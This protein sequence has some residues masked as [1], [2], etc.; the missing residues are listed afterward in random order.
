MVGLGRLD[1][2]AKGN[3]RTLQQGKHCLRIQDKEVGKTIRLAE[4]L[5]SF[6]FQKCTNASMSGAPSTSAVIRQRLQEADYQGQR[7]GNARRSLATPAFEY[8]QKETETVCCP[9]KRSDQTI[10]SNLITY[11][12]KE[13]NAK[14]VSQCLPFGG[15]DS[16]DRSE[17]FRRL[18]TADSG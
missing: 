17:R 18:D 15:W 8:L 11:R 5:A 12:L 4:Q 14:L 13:L 6:T 10:T 7:K 2:A 1:I 16:L 3:M 9:Q